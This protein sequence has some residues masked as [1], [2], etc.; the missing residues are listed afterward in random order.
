MPVATT[1]RVSLCLANESVDQL[2]SREEEA[3][4]QAKGKGRNRVDYWRK[5]FDHSR[6]ELKKALTPLSVR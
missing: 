2:I 1:L 3:L 6:P 4:Y 5:P